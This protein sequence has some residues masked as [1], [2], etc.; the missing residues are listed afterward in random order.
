MKTPF[1]FLSLHKTSIVIFLKCIYV[2]TDL[3]TIIYCAY[4]YYYVNWTLINSLCI[5][6]VA[7]FL[8]IRVIFTYTLKFLSC[9]FLFIQFYFYILY[10]YFCATMYYFSFIFK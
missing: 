7:Y 9:I 5:Y 8:N 2:L 1:I 4:M 3:Y 10:F 6:I